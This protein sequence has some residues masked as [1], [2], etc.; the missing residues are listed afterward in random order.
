MSDFL[1]D[2]PGT[3]SGWLTSGIAN[4]DSAKEISSV[5]EIRLDDS[6]LLALATLKQLLLSLVLGNELFQNK[7][8]VVSTT[9]TAIDPNIQ[10]ASIQLLVLH[11]RRVSP[12]RPASYAQL[13]QRA[14]QSS[15]PKSF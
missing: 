3:T 5:G 1:P 9:I 11:L 4:L 12:R 7:P 13:P 14:R 6:V 2:N 8:G 15:G 10:G